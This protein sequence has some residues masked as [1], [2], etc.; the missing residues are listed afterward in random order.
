MDWLHA[1]LLTSHHYGGGLLGRVPHVVAGHAAVDPRLAGGDGR[2]RERATLHHAPLW[3]AVVAA[4]P[5]ED[6]RRLA[7]GGNAH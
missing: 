7:T 2:K 3:Q 5:G 4:D 1:Y 6:G